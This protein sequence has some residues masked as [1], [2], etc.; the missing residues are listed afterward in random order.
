MKTLLS[1]GAT[2]LLLAMTAISGS[3]LPHS[4][5]RNGKEGIAEPDGD[6]CS[7]VTR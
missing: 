7:G 3:P 6:H 2:S 5:N 1:F 4:Q